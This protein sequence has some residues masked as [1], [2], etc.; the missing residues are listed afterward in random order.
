M[1]DTEKPPKGRRPTPPFDPRF[2]NQNQTRNCYQN[3]L[4]AALDG[5]DPGRHLRGEN[6]TVCTPAPPRDPANGPVPSSPGDRPRP[7]TPGL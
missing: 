2:P 5:A 3:F 4:G 1:Y 6:L 7:P